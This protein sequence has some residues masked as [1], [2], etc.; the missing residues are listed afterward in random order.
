MAEHLAVRIRNAIRHKSEPLWFPRLTAGLAHS[1][2]NKLGVDLH[3][4]PSSYG[5]ARVLH[6]DPEEPLGI[7]AFCKIP[8]Y[9]REVC[10]SIPIE[11]VPQD[12]ALHYM[13]SGVRFF[14]A[15]E[16][17]HSGAIDTLTAALEVLDGV[18]TLLPSICTLVRS[19]HL[20][21]PENDE[22]DVSFSEPVLPFS[23]FVSVPR[24][25]VEAS[26]L[27]VAEGLLHEAM[28][29]QLTLIESNVPL[30]KPGERTYF[31]PWRN[32]YRAPQGVLHALYV[33]RVIHAFLGLWTL[34]DQARAESQFHANERRETIARQIKDIHEFRNSEDL[35]PEGVAFV[36]RLLA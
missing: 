25:N 31:S 14:N 19:L 4:T 29:L 3:I 26:A 6:N 34:S 11:I 30:V 12:L 16:V 32:E 2:W 7:V 8:A 24:S 13:D 20:I 18:P 1:A 10:D 28:H 33:F 21:D 22:I 35:T 9:Y 5:T 23:V 27:R 17:I 36:D 15:E